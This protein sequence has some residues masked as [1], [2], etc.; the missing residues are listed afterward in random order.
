MTPFCYIPAYKRA[1]TWASLI[2]VSHRNRLIGLMGRFLG[3]DPDRG[4]KAT[5]AEKGGHRASADAA[6]GGLHLVHLLY[7]P[8]ERLAPPAR[9]PE[10][11]GRPVAS[12]PRLGS[13][14]PPPRRPV[15]SKRRAQRR[16]FHIL[17][18]IGGHHPAV[19]VK[20]MS[21]PGTVL[22][23]STPASLRVGSKGGA[24]RGEHGVALGKAL[25]HL[26][27]GHHHAGGRP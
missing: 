1:N 9:R 25:R 3:G 24:R 19:D 14:W 21:C 22:T 13:P 2:K 18:G 26:V 10:W 4:R 8:L 23:F 27:H 20:D 11:A 16:L 5:A 12:A 17:Q 15:P 6:G 7:G